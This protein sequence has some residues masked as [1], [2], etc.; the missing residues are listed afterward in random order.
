MEIFVWLFGLFCIVGIAI[1][2]WRVYMILNHPKEYER[3]RRYERE[4][5]EKQKEAAAKVAGVAKKGAAFGLG[6]LLKVLTKR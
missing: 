1:G 4:L 6:L 2:I 5:E 3:L